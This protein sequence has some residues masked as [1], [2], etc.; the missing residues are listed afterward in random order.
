ME[1][2]VFGQSGLLPTSA[3]LEYF[4][5]LPQIAGMLFAATFGAFKAGGPFLLVRQLLRIVLPAVNCK[6]VT[7]AHAT[8]ELNTIHLHGWSPP[9]EIMP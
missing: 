3:A 8:L 2:S 6:K 5:G 1:D 9:E 7:Q 4:D